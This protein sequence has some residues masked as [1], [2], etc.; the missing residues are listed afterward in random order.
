MISTRRR[1]GVGVLDSDRYRRPDLK[2]IEA[3]EDTFEHNM[4]LLKD[5]IST[6]ISAR[7]IWPARR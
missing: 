3:D 2:V 5:S 4:A 6:P 1:A 7:T